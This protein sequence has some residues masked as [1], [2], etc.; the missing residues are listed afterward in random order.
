MFGVWGLSSHTRC[1]WKVGTE[2]KRPR[3]RPQ[4]GA[5]GLAVG[6]RR[7]GPGVPAPDLTKATAEGLALTGSSG[8]V[9]GGLR[10]GPTPQVGL[11][12]PRRL[13]QTGPWLPML[14]SQA[15]DPGPGPLSESSEDSTA[16]PSPASWA[17]CGDA[18]H[19]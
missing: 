9:K 7:G 11:G 10:C 8:V 3:L 12:V 16:Q 2:R 18:G 15:W 19:L 1:P 4:G 14:P 13:Q 5:I 17:K 6:Q